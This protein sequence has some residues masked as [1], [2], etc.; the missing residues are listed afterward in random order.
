MFL[1]N[2]DIFHVS[3]IHKPP[4][5]SITVRA[6]EHVIPTHHPLAH[7]PRLPVKSPVLETIAPLPAHPVL[8][9]LILIPELH[10]DS[11]IREGK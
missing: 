4:T 5:V 2:R 11:V 10:R 3:T 6:D 7:L 1:S 9:V 8:G